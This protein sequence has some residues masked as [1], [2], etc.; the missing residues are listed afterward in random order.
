MNRITAPGK[1]R[2]EALA[3][4]SRIAANSP[5]AVRESLRVTR[6][7]ADLCEAD[8]RATQDDAVKHVLAAGDY[9]EGA[10]AFVE[11][12]APRVVEL[13]DRIEQNK[14][15]YCRE[16]PACPKSRR[17]NPFWMH[18]CLARASQDCTLYIACVRTGSR[19]W[20]SS[21]RRTWAVRGTGIRYPGARCDVESL[22][23]CYTF[24]PLL[25]EGWQW[26][27]RYAQARRDPGVPELGREQ[28]GPTTRHSLQL[29][30]GLRGL[31]R[32]EES[33]DVSHGARRDLPCAAFL[34][35]G[36]PDYH[37]GHART[38][39]DSRTSRAW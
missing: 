6:Y 18:S 13:S 23:Y 16:N 10:K 27:E 19:C 15:V 3:I 35:G 8:L 12:R 22:V 17:W 37:A 5:I 7:A 25:D 14:F 30:R 9:Q 39:Q 2:E 31:R 36:R 32:Q 21:P 29:P 26:S 1:V 34:L 38:F 11:R 33:V 20:R 28:A 24:S 4:A